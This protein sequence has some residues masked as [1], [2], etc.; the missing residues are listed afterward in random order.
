MTGYSVIEQK[1]VIPTIFAVMYTAEGMRGFY[2]RGGFK[3][4]E[5]AWAAIPDRTKPPGEEP[6]VAFFRDDFAGKTPAYL[7]GE[8]ADSA[9]RIVRDPCP[10]DVE[11][12]RAAL[13]YAVAETTSVYIGKK[14][15][16]FHAKI[17]H[18]RYMVAPP[19]R[20]ICLGVDEFTRLLDWIQG[21]EGKGG[22]I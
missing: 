10:L 2:L 18:G 1:N 7:R 21:I 3:T 5:A 16:T 12:L 14:G 20:F 8:P 15:T 6:N 4:P 17:P 22:A 11:E 9:D 19:D 13:G